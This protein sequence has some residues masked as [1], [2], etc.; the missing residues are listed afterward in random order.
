MYRSRAMPSQTALTRELLIIIIHRSNYSTWKNFHGFNFRRLE[1]STFFN[2]ENFPIYCICSTD[3]RTRT[4]H[5]S[6]LQT[7]GTN[8]ALF[9]STHLSMLMISSSAIFHCHA[10]LSLCRLYSTYHTESTFTDPMRWSI[11]FN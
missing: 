3:P 4:S 6:L 2:H 1:E 11:K 10:K 9:S 8:D 5:M 7:G